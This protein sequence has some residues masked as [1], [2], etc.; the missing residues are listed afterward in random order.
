MFLM[1]PGSW[2][3]DIFVDGIFD[4]IGVR[5]SYLFGRVYVALLLV[6]VIFV[7]TYDAR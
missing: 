7:G 6:K 5:L 3:E 4:R 1:L 2:G